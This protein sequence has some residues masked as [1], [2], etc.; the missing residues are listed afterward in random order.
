MSAANTQQAQQNVLRIGAPRPTNEPAPVS[1]P[2]PTPQLQRP[3]R[4]VARWEHFESEH[5]SLARQYME[6]FGN[7]EDINRLFS[8]AFNL[9]R[10]VTVIVRE[11]EDGAVYRYADSTITFCYSFLAS[12]ERSRA[13][14]DELRVSGMF[15]WTLMHEM[16]HALIADL[17]L[18]IV[19]SH[20]DAADSFATLWLVGSGENGNR[21]L[22]SAARYFHQSRRRRHDANDYADEHSLDPQRFYNMLCIA[23]GANRRSYLQAFGSDELPAARA[24]RCRVEY[25]QATVGW[26]RLLAPHSNIDT[27]ESFE[28]LSED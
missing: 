15:F 25:N 26:N 13:T 23:R 5:A 28:H 2:Q 10:A 17:R 12:L 19:A 3:D 4:V 22:A 27:R 18:P 14:D 11:C 1:A 20:E 16:A 9:P 21:I 7:F 24:E 8:Y 6:V